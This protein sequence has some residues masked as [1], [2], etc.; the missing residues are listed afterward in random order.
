VVTTPKSFGVFLGYQAIG[1][2]TVLKAFHHCVPYETVTD[3][4]IRSDFKYGLI[5][6]GDKH[7]LKI[8]PGNMTSFIFE[9]NMY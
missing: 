2:F 1:Y 3:K 9:I 8:M 4:D 7:V 5:D 6:F